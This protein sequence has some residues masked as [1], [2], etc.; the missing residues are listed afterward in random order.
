[1]ARFSIRTILVWK[2]AKRTRL[3][4]TFL[5]SYN[6][7]SSLDLQRNSSCLVFPRSSFE[8]QSGGIARPQV[9]WWPY[10]VLK[11]LACDLRQKIPCA[12]PWTLFLLFVL[13]PAV[14]AA[15][16]WHSF[17]FPAQTAETKSWRFPDQKGLVMLC[18]NDRQIP[19]HCQGTAYL[20]R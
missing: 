1:M 8:D 14:A 19:L 2:S 12:A 11:H 4:G 6:F 10:L 20:L 9:L 18:C 3:K 13:L 15:K 17:A 7:G 5:D 16:I